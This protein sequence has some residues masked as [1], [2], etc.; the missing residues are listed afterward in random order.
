MGVSA[1]RPTNSTLK[2][3]SFP[4]DKKNWF[5]WVNNWREPS[6]LPKIAPFGIKI[7]ICFIFQKYNKAITQARF[8]AGYLLPGYLLNMLVS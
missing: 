3:G 5:T 8:S 2:M 4:I 1:C 7:D 6:R